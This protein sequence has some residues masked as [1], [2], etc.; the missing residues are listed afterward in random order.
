MML[1]GQCSLVTCLT[2]PLFFTS[3]ITRQPHL[4]RLIRLHTHAAA[5]N[6]MALAS[7][8]AAGTHAAAASSAPATAAAV[9]SSGDCESFVRSADVCTVFLSSKGSISNFMAGFSAPYEKVLMR[10]PGA[11]V[12]GAGGEVYYFTRK[13]LQRCVLTKK[14]KA[15]VQLRDWIQQV[16]LDGIMKHGHENHQVPR[17][18]LH[19][20]GGGA[21][22][23]SGGA[24]DDESKEEEEQEESSKSS[25]ALSRA[26]LALP[27]PTAAQLASWVQASLTLVAS[28][29]KLE[30]DRA[31]KHAAIAAASPSQHH[32]AGKDWAG[33]KFVGKVTRLGNRF[34][35]IIPNKLTKKQQSNTRTQPQQLRARCC[36][37]GPLCPLAHTPFVCFVC[38][39]CCRLE[40]N[41]GDRFAGEALVS[42][43]SAVMV[44]VAPF[45][46]WPR[47][48]LDD[49]HSR[50]HARAAWNHEQIMLLEARRST[51]TGRRAEDADHNSS[52]MAALQG[53]SA[54]HIERHLASLQQEERHRLEAKILASAFQKANRQYI[55]KDLGQKKK[56]T[57]QQGRTRA[58]VRLF[59]RSLLILLFPLSFLVCVILFP[60]SLCR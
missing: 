17:E 15:H 13:G 45:A 57:M 31:A 35:A 7:A 12:G 58:T 60:R 21:R 44:V 34:Q 29:Q 55:K 40:E 9:L 14:V 23:G 5:P 42:S 4:I 33:T 43:P 10:V 25:K 56:R 51:A 41:S 46:P 24:E 2:Q 47:L 8:A 52:A 30:N 28:T 54:H 6:N 16:L 20:G 3:Q 38:F 22:G 19:G 32:S 50:R 27:V 49:V 26:S 48:G 53:V 11:G 18:A 37:G 39:V 1:D 59:A 36:V